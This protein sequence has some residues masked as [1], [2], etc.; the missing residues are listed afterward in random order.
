MFHTIYIY[1]INAFRLCNGFS[2]HK[3][4]FCVRTKR[5]HY[6]LLHN[7]FLFWICWCWALME[8]IRWQKKNQSFILCLSRSNCIVFFSM[9]E[10]T[11]AQENIEEIMKKKN[12]DAFAHWIN[13]FSLTV[14]FCV[15]SFFLHLFIYLFFL[16]RLLSMAHTPPRVKREKLRT[17]HNKHTHRGVRRWCSVLH[18]RWIQI[19][20]QLRQT[21]LARHQRKV[22]AKWNFSAW[23]I[24]RNNNRMEY[25]MWHATISGSQLYS[26]ES[27]KLNTNHGIRWIDLL[28]LPIVRIQYYRFI[29]LRC[30]QLNTVL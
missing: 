9:F 20:K 29:L 26:A 24:I 17:A 15:F 3:C 4:T 25:C 8:F 19:N 13:L 5:P 10:S 12:T 11:S 18:F 16:A 14:Y 27:S 2:Q 30:P 21:T 6:W 28:L 22:N 7:E 23:I 1:T